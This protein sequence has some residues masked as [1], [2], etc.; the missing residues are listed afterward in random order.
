M[1]QDIY[2]FFEINN[3]T[4]STGPTGTSGQ[5]SEAQMADI[6]TAGYQ[7]VINLAL[8]DGEYSLH[9]ERA[10]VEGLGM[11]YIH[12]PVIW[13]KPNQENFRNFC[14]VMEAHQGKKVF[15][16]C[17]ANMRVSAFMALYRITRLGVAQE[18]A[19]QDMHQVWTPY[20]WWETFIEQVLSNPSLRQA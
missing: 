8:H 20:D 19:F 9:D 10:T 6:A 15:V 18:Q 13:Q 7:T 4:S 14:E 11:E 2:N 16:H 1:L 12:I 5:P 3:P 17:A